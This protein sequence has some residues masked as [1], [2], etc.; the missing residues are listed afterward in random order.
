[1]VSAQ[2]RSDVMLER[3]RDASLRLWQESG[4]SVRVMA[5]GVHPYVSGAAHRIACFEAMLDHLMGMAGVVF[6]NGDTIC[7]WFTEQVR[8]PSIPAR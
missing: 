1:M 8:P 3:V 7:D 2:H 6:W 5:F 4:E